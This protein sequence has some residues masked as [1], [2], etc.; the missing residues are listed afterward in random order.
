MSPFARLALDPDITSHRLEAL[1]ANPQA[2]ACAAH[3]C[4]KRPLQAYELMEEL[5]L[6]HMCNPLAKVAHPHTRPSLGRLWLQRVWTSLLCQRR[7]GLDA[8]RDQAALGRRRILERITQ[9]VGKNRY[10]PLVDA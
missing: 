6:F 9:E 3:R 2:Q 8:S 4:G 5:V 1:A 7:A 10:K